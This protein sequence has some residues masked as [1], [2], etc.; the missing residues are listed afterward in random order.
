[1]L[2]FAYGAN[3]NT[4]NMEIR[5]PNATLVGTGML[6][7]FAFLCNTRGV[8]SIEPSPG[9]S[10]YGV[11][12]KLTQEDEAFLDLFEGV[13]GG[14]YTKEYLMV[15][16]EDARRECLVYIASNNT[17][18][19]GVRDYLETIVSDCKGYGFPEDYIAHLSS[20][21]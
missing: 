12:W 2:Y 14:W 8:A 18:G 21:L 3:L 5:C 1:M 15:S 20:S 11:I 16:Q 10:V 9:N 6:E 13:N 17:K 19:K 7:N 4:E